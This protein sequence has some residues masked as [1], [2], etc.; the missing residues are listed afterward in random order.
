VSVLN[1]ISWSRRTVIALALAAA[2][3]AGPG[4]LPAYGVDILVLIFVFGILA[5]GLDVLMGYTGMD[6]LGQGAFFGTAAY[7]LGILTVKSGINWFAAAGIA[8][9]LA[10]LLAGVIGLLA[11]RLRG[12]YFLLITLAFGQVLWGGALRWGDITGGFNG[13]SGVPRPFRFLSDVVVFA[14]VTLVIFVITVAAVKVIVSSPFGLALQGC[15]DNEDRLRTLGFRPFQL[16]W[17]AFVIAGATAGLAGVMNATYNNFVSPSDLSLTLSFSLMLMVIMGGAGNIVGAVVG[18]AIVTALQYGLSI[19]IEDWWL[20]LLGVVYMVTTI[21]LPTGVVGALRA[22]G[23]QRQ[24]TEAIEAPMPAPRFAANDAIA[25]PVSV[26]PSTPGAR[27]AVSSS[28]PVLALEGVGKAFGGVR[29]LDNVTVSFEQGERTA[30]IGPNG[31]GK[32]TLFNLITGLEPVSEGRITVLG[33]DVTRRPAYARPALGMARTFQV[34]RLF[35]PLTVLDNMILGLLGWSARQYQFA[36]WR[37]TSMIGELQHRAQEELTTMRLHHLRDV[38]VRELSYGHQKQLDIA[39]A[40]ACRPKVLLLDE[41]TAGLS[42]TEALTIVE[43]V[44]ALPDEITV[45]IIEHN[46]DFLF[47]LTDRLI[48]LDHGT[49]LID[50]S[51]QAVRN[52]EDVRRIYFGATV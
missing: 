8:V 41:P 13:L 49:I 15:R 39:M 19:Y 52:S 6:S 17:L 1:R 31:A 16:R 4:L 50:G 37:P 28:P 29:V 30:I 2:L 43:F 18:A 44:K 42:R 5:V 34:T 7:T 21:F 47:S 12:L 10:T 51:Q 32:T 22:I 23:R 11:V 36:L 40:L 38:P 25:L 35:P 24:A 33:T 27:T 48:V 20:L 45:I 9:V 3:V 26:Q 46:L 14:Y